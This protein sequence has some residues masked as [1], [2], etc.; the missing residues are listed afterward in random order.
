MWLWREV[1][2]CERGV[3]DVYVKGEMCAVDVAE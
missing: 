3:W 1:L 2:E